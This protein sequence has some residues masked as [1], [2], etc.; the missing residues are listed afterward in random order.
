[1]DV[2]ALYYCVSRS[3]FNRTFSWFLLEHRFCDGSKQKLSFI[4][5]KDVYKSTFEDREDDL[6]NVIVEPVREH[7]FSI[8]SN[9]SGGRE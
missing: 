7:F 6:V 5:T 1:M 9:Q 8:R 3:H 2:L 4:T